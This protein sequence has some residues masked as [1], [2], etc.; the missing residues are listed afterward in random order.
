MIRLTLRKRRLVL[1]TPYLGTRPAVIVHVD[2]HE[3]V[4][5]L[6]IGFECP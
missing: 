6:L 1:E 5:E 4:H 2:E 3:V